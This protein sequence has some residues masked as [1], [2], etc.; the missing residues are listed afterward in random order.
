MEIKRQKKKVL[1]MC[2][3]SYNK[4]LILLQEFKGEQVPKEILL[5]WSPF[6]VQI[7]NLPLKCR[8]RETRHTIGSTLGEVIKVDV[9][10]IGVQWGKCLR[11]RVKVD[12][13]KKIS[14]GEEDNH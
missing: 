5:Q 2:P 11:V 4:Q 6:W 13:T 8:T 1:E 14:E 10:E 3:W 7:H 12:V 9:A